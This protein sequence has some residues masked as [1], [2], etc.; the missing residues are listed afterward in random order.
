[1]YDYNKKFTFCSLSLICIVR[2]LHSDIMKRTRAD[3]IGKQFGKLTVNEFSHIG[4]YRHA[5]W[6]CKC[7]CGG[8]RVTSSRQLLGG[9]AK[10]C[11][12]IHSECGEKNKNWKGCGEISLSFFNKIKSD[13]IRRSLPFEIT[14]KECWE[15]FINQKRM[16][17]LSGL[18]I[19]FRTKIKTFDG[20]ASLDRI[21]SSK[22]YIKNNIQWVHKDINL[23]KWN[24]PLNR[25]LYLV[26]AINRNTLRGAGVIG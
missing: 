1:M 5:Y 8:I 24:F 25:F 20:S 13:A 26:D 12:C 16:C 19:N 10:S 15:L 7:D 18:P 9:R 23:M 4:N 3:L 22:G 2:Y 14:I 21:D 11:G 17:K 6:V